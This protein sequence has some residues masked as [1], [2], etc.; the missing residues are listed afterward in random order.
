M[1]PKRILILDDSE[2]I[3]EGMKMFLELKNYTVKTQNH[4][5]N[6]FAEISG[7]NPDLIILDIYLQGHDGREICKN[8][9]QSF[10]A[11]PPKIIL[12]S[13]ASH[14]LEGYQHFG[15]DDFLEKPFGLFDIYAK[16]E[17]VLNN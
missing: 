6:I 7:F 13:G 16:I 2:D 11:K 10:K 1:P 17:K 5:N 8:I 12:F 9:K 14:A 3:L 4:V 15:A